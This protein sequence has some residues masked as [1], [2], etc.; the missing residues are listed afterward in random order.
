MALWK[1]LLMVIALICALHTTSGGRP[2]WDIPLLVPPL[3]GAQ[4]A[5]KAPSATLQVQ[6]HHNYTVSY[7]F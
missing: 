3:T 4:D 7:K 5:P 1:V 2:S 6:P